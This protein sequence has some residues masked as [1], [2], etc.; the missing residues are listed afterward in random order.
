MAI[1][2]K[3]CKLD[4]FE[5]HNSLKFSF[6]VIRGRRSNLVECEYFLESNSPY[7]LALC[8]TNLDD[9]I[10]TG[11][12]S[13]RGNLPLIRK[14]SA[15]HVHSVS[16]FFFLHRSPSLSLCK[17]FDGISSNIDEVL[18]INPSTNPMR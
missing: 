3:G 16:Y 17:V 5:S 13:L 18:S 14:D 12:F 15:T 4:N 9:S 8:D 6:T 2:S 7:I 11:N 1:L 10:D